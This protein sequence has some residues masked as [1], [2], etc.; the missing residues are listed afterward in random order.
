MYRVTL[1]DEQR[2]QL[3]QRAHQPGI[4]P[5][6]RDRLEM[7]RLAD[8]GWHIPQIAVHL[9]QHEQT[10]R[11]WIKA[12]LRGSFDALDNKPRGGALSALTPTVLL[13]VQKEVTTSERTWNADQIAAFIAQRFG[14]QRSADQVRRKLRQAHMSYKRTRRHLRHKQKPEEVA[15]KKAQLDTLEKKGT[16]AN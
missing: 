14:I 15:S 6:T 1:T 2:Q 11:Y 13:A 9:N 8:A 7:L 12:F 5:S 16:A 4:T 10:V 3:N